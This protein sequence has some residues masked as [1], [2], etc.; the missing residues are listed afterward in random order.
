MYYVEL[1][2]KFG[3]WKSKFHFFKTYKKTLDNCALFPEY[4]N[5]NQF[6]PSIV[7]SE[8]YTYHAVSQ[9]IILNFHKKISIIIRIQNLA[10]EYT[11]SE[12]GNF[13]Q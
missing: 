1:Y 8:I 3:S 4:D 10:V 7:A 5:V 9:N 2:K 11:R 13:A 12:N 6:K